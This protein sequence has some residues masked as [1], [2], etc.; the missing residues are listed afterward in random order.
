[1]FDFS[2]T[3]AQ[4]EGTGTEAEIRTEPRITT[5]K[6]DPRRVTLTA[7]K[8]SKGSTNIIVFPIEYIED[9]QWCTWELGNIGGKSQVVGKSEK[10]LVLYVRPP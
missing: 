8:A 10:G 5:P 4:E 9:G 6:S 3:E 7:R 2:H 1:M